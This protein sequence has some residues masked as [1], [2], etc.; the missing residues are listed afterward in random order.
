M[1][2]VIPG[3]SGDLL[4]AQLAAAQFLRTQG[5]ANECPPGLRFAAPGMTEALYVPHLKFLQLSRRLK[6]LRQIV[7]GCLLAFI[8]AAALLE[9]VADTDNSFERWNEFFA[10]FCQFIFDRRR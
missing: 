8:I 9:F 5:S 1:R 2:T 6:C 7:L 10:N 4:S 3:S